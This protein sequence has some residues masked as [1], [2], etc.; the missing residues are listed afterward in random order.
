V[1]L[2]PWVIGAIGW[3]PSYMLQIVSLLPIAFVA[4]LSETVIAG[5]G[6]QVSVGQAGFMAVGAYTTGLLV[7]TLHWPWWAGILAGAA[8]GAIVA[9][10]VGI[11][12]L[13]LRGPYFVMAS[14]AF[15]GIVYTVAT[16]WLEVTG[17]PGGLRNIPIPDFDALGLHP[18]TGI[19][20]ILWIAAAAS[21]LGVRWFRHTPLGR[22]LVAI[23]E[24]ELAARAVGVHTALV[25][26]LGFVF[27]GTLAGLAGAL[28]PLFIGSVTPDAFGVNQS[29]L[30]LTQALIGGL[31]RIAG[32][33]VG[34]AVLLGM[35]ELLRD[36]AEF[37]LL[38]YG[39]AMLTVVLFF[40][41]G[42]VGELSGRFGWGR[43]TPPY[44]QPLGRGPGDPGRAS[45]TPTDR[46]HTPPG[47]PGRASTTPTDGPHTASAA[48]PP[49]STPLLEARGLTKRFGGLVAVENVNLAV[50]RGT[51]SSL[52]GPNGAGK[53][54]IFNLLSGITRPD[55][56]AILLGGVDV[57]G[58]PS[59]RMARAGVCRT[60]QNPRLFWN[61][62]VLDNVGVAIQ[63]ERS[64]A[65]EMWSLLFA[66]R[67]QHERA[68]EL[69]DVVGLAD[70]AAELARSLPYGH[71]R[72]LELARALAGN[73]KIVMLDEPVAGMNPREVDDLMTLL[74]TI[75]ARGV[76]LLLIEHNMRMVL[77]ISDHVSVLNFGRL[78]AEGTPAAVR[79]D[80]RVIEAYLGAEA[81]R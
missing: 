41:R 14:L 47:D 75:R 29:L 79:D 37:Q 28:L 80:T 21:I 76:T 36:F 44:P 31:D 3:R 81:T 77:D 49:S 54:T 66:E 17:G 4:T 25:K 62:S 70:R 7:G 13:R 10:L 16:N 27:S 15:G 56:G 26:S 51:I 69:L 65:G 9:G 24:D 61:L 72:R 6:G 8:S 2:S 58:S 5:F 63:R 52:I 59:W 57:T 33:I 18:D 20:Y 12:A 42:V 11:P 60:F 1:V 64:L 35:T 71:L 38:F 68:M 30:I 50:L 55:A 78:I 46:P 32:A 45:T 34:S 23:R 67:A 48:S 73:A 53:T 39:V 74:E 40:P 22:S 19:Y 43:R